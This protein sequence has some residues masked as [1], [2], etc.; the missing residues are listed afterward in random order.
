MRTMPAIKT[1]S[2]S[3][4]FFYRGHDPK[5][6]CHLQ[7]S[8]Q[9]YQTQLDLSLPWH[10]ERSDHCYWKTQHKDIQKAE[11]RLRDCSFGLPYK[12]VLSNPSSSLLNQPSLLPTQGRHRSVLNTLSIPR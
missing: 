1:L 4:R 6:F 7:S 2:L 3:A 11:Y 5:E 8:Y 9:K 12:V 10:M